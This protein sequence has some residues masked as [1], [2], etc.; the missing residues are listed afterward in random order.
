MSLVFAFVRF[1]F[2]FFSCRFVCFV[3]FTLFVYLSI[4]FYSLIDIFYSIFFLFCYSTHIKQYASVNKS[5]PA[6]TE[7]T[8][9]SASTFPRFSWPPFCLNYFNMKTFTIQKSHAL[10]LFL[11]FAFCLFLIVLLRTMF[12]TFVK[13][14]GNICYGKLSQWL[15]CLAFCHVSIP[16]HL[17]QLNRHPLVRKQN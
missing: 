11:C 13:K 7:C 16:A 1:F 3:L 15:C 9:A 6:R 12:L 10:R 5:F 4:Y 17:N 2:L 14:G 8:H